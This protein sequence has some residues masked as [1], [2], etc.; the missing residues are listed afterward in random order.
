MVVPR[1]PFDASTAPMTCEHNRDQLRPFGCLGCIIPRFK[2]M[3]IR[4][5]L[6]RL[7]QDEDAD[8]QLHA[9]AGRDFFMDMLS[10]MGIDLVR[11]GWSVR[12]VTLDMR[13]CLL[14]ETVSA[15]LED[16]A[17]TFVQLENQKEIR[18][19]PG[20]LIHRTRSL[21]PIFKSVLENMN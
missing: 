12:N 17:L 7:L 19:S 5:A 18:F 14:M 9:T 13:G 4:V 16:K 15:S 1:V 20:D 8:V 3:A 2:D 11:Y 10:H 6:L 21:V